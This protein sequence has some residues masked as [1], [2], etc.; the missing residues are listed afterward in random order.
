MATKLKFIQ[1]ITYGIGRT[2]DN[3]TTFLSASVKEILHYKLSFF[4]TI[5]ISKQ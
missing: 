5:S 3:Y 1:L 4:Y 2:R